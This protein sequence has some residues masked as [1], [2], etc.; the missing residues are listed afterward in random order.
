MTQTK[1][2]QKTKTTKFAHNEILKDAPT[3]GLSIVGLGVIGMPLAAHGAEAIIDLSKSLLPEDT[4]AREVQA[5]FVVTPRIWEI[6]GEKWV[7]NNP[8]WNNLLK[9]LL[10]KVTTELGLDDS[11]KGICSHKFSLL[12]FE[13][14]SE[15]V[16]TK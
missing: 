11:N 7:T 14:G 6:L 8:S 10:P 1:L 3:P 15:G 13:A 16:K 12:L 2:S 4:S 5:G 9:S